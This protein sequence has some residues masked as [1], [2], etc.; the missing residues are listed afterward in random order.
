[1]QQ[2]AQSQAL[3]VPA[4]LNLGQEAVVAVVEALL[5]GLWDY[6]YSY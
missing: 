5:V 3:V 4:E 1:M 6:A 2:Q